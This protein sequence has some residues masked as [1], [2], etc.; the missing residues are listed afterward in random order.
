MEDIKAI[1]NDMLK[2]GLITTCPYIYG[3]NR[4]IEMF[5]AWGFFPEIA[6]TDSE[7]L[8]NRN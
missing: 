6:P 3:S 5:E 7:L 8:E 2:R 4:L 1:F